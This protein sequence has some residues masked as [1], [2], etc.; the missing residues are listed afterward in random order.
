VTHPKPYPRCIFCGAKANSREHAIP[1]WVSKQL[2]VKTI[3]RGDSWGMTGML[4]HP[5]SFAS[6]RGRIFCKGCNHHFKHLEDAVIPL[7]V[8]MARG[9]SLALD[10]DSQALL[11]LWAAKTGIAILV[12]TAPE[13]LEVVPMEHR[14][15][16][17][18]AGMLNEEMW[19]AYFPWHGRTVI[20][21]GLVRLT[22][23]QVESPDGYEAY[24]LIFAVRKV[25][26]R[27]VGFNGP[28]HERDRIGATDLAPL[29]QLWAAD[30][31]LITWPE[32]RPLTEAQHLPTIVNLAPVRP[33]ELP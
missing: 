8:P 3:L 24:S 30:R 15:S 22:K 9:R 32:G 14:R 17:R 13:L 33:R 26:F 31:S 6:H 18:D 20:H 23:D 7:L 19:V 16:I 28:I 12:T 2:G 29:T 11:A 21:G 25:G 4:R 27:L 1:K 10:A 5:I